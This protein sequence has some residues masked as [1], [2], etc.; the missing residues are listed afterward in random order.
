MV[1]GHGRG[2]S[3]NSHVNQA[4]RMPWPAEP[5]CVP[6]KALDN[7][8]SEGCIEVLAEC[9]SLP[10][11]MERRSGWEVSGIILQPPLHQGQGTWNRLPPTDVSANIVA[12]AHLRDAGEGI[13]DEVKGF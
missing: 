7:S 6:I 4:A 10:T 12:P 3:G 2:C 5:A 1:G 11:Y 13:D 8:V 9:K